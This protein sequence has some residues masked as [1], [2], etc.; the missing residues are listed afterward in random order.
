[1]FLAFLVKFTQGIILLLLK[2]RQTRVALLRQLVKLLLPRLNNGRPRS[3]HGLQLLLICHFS[4]HD[5]AILG[6]ARAGLLN[7]ALCVCKFQGVGEVSRGH[8]GA[9]PPIKNRGNI[10]AIVARDPASVAVQNIF[11]D[12][13]RR[14]A[15]HPRGR[16]VNRAAESLEQMRVREAAADRA[17]RPV[18]ACFLGFLLA[19]GDGRAGHLGNAL[20]HSTLY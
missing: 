17:E 20:V 3:H 13:L 6:L 15:R 1:V 2:I 19:E 14:L 10:K 7:E 9:L 11:G 8:R 4:S 18:A 12:L 5:F 16:H